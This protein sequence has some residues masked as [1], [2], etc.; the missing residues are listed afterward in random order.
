MM[1]PQRRSRR[2]IVVVYLGLLALVIPWYWP[3]DDT[4]HAF[5]LPLWVIVTLIALLVT[6]VF[7]AWVFLTSPE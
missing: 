2:W 4:R 5:G 3:A 7:T 1:E 6:S